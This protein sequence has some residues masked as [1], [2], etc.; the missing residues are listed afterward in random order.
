MVSDE[1]ARTVDRRGRKRCSRQGT[2]DRTAIPIGENEITAPVRFVRPALTGQAPETPP[3][4]PES[5][6]MC[7]GET[8][9][10]DHCQSEGTPPAAPLQTRLRGP[11]R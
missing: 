9:S 5:T 1:Y 3:A 6:S 11:G 2:A 10:T 7:H 8:D 4:K